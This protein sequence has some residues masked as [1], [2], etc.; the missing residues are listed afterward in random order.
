[1]DE[2]LRMSIGLHLL[3]VVATMA[4]AALHVS[5]LWFI[6]DFQ[7]L[8]KKI[9][10]LIPAYYFMLSCLFFTGL[11]A[12]AVL[13]F[14]FSHAVVTMVVAWMLLLG[15]S[16]KG[17]GLFKRTKFSSEEAVRQR[18]VAF[19]KKKYLF[20]LCVLALLVAIA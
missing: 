20:D 6:K 13:H 10:A 17:Y 5:L 3:F 2:L 14:H 11:I 1:M 15:G 12:W 9:H 19:A 7:S 4:M 18:F 8:G 16:I